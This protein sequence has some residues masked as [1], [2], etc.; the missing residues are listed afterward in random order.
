MLKGAEQK[1]GDPLENL[2][3][4]W[5]HLI[6]ESMRN[7]ARAEAYKF[8]Q[9]TK[10]DLI[11]EVGAKDIYT[12]RS[13]KDKKV[14]FVHKRTQESVLSFQN[15]GKPV[16]FKVNHPELF[17]ALSQLNTQY[18]DNFLMRLMGKAKR[19]LTFGATFGPGFR[20]ANLL[21]DT[22]HTAMINKSFHPFIDTGRGF[23]KSLN[24]SEDYIALMA[25]GA[26]FG[27]SYVRA[28]DPQ[29]AAKYIKRIIKKEG[30]GAAERIL[31]TPKKMLEFWEKIG[32]AS[33]NAARVE[34]YSNL[35]K[36][37]VSHREAAFEARDL[38][39][40]TMRGDA[41]TVQFLIQTVPFL[42]ARMQG[43]YKLGRAAVTPDNIKNFILRGSMLM[44]TT[45]ALWYWNRDRDEWKELEDWDKWAYYHFWIGSKHFRF[46]K[47]FEVGAIFS[48]LPETM[49][50]TLYG[51]EQ[52]K[53]IA[54]FL[55]YT[56]KETFAIGVPQLFAPI[57]E[58][59]ANKSSFTG[60]PIVPAHLKGLKPG[61]QKEPWTSET[62]QLVGKLGIS[63]KRAEALINGYF[64]TFGT[65]VLGGTDIVVR[66]TMNFPERPT[67]RIDNYPLVGRFIKEKT[68]AR[69]TKYQSWFYE[70]FKEIDELTR[71]MNHYAQ[72]GEP[73]KAKKIAE[74][75]VKQLR[76]R[77][78]FVK[79]R[80]SLGRINKQ[81][82]SI[83]IDR[84]MPSKKKRN[85]L[86]S[87][88]EQRNNLVKKMYRIYYGKKEN[89]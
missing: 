11:E 35:I 36:K 47:P 5:M 58:Q 78:G 52:S 56:A 43:L 75:E 30:S 66:N 68:P 59:W 57:L 24:E 28:E 42:N 10:S 20:I 49:M 7:V 87:L 38:L 40:F 44:A 15:K 89:D 77:H 19:T 84:K 63:P 69:Y 61:E 12:F 50:D 8:A 2:M 13:S 85:K 16:Y 88:Y 65:F 67:V 27:S 62:V 39:D 79:V 33:E 46:P 17:N 4:N 76:Y 3:H 6:K 86:E 21:R 71:T 26:G 18:L 41:S 82:K 37:G 1:M 9:Q 22:L 45:L 14:T 51:N 25:S 64:S 34:L 72:T 31:D 55:G 70:T 23:V 54:N 73:Q 74:S 48:S 53:H 83:M 81:I 80:N 29:V 60:R 32:S